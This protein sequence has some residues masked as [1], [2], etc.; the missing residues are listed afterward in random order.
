MEPKYPQQPVYLSTQHTVQNQRPKR[1]VVALPVGDP[2]DAKS[3]WYLLGERTLWIWKSRAINHGWYWYG[4]SDPRARDE[5][6]Y[7]GF[8]YDPAEGYEREAIKWLHPELYETC[9][10]Y[11]MPQTPLIEDTL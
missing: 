1:W 9:G 7:L 8:E 4:A 3:R 5:E 11:S 6:E 10:I 2:N